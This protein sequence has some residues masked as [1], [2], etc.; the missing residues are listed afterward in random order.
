MRKKLFM[1]ILPAS[2]LLSQMQMIQAEDFAGNEDYYNNLCAQPQETSADVQTCANYKAYLVSKSDALSNEIASLNDKLSNV[3]GNMDSLLSVIS[4]IDTKLTSIETEIASSEALIAT[5]QTNITN[6]QTD[7]QEKEEDIQER[8]E[9]VKTRMQNEQVNIGINQY[10]DFIMGAE[11]LMSLI[12]IVEGLNVIT[13]YDQELIAT[14]A[15]ERE[16]LKLDKEEQIR[17]E[18]EAEDQRQMLE[19]NKQNQQVL[20]SHQETALAQYQSEEA[21]LIATKRTMEVSS[22]VLANN[23][24]H[25]NPELIQEPDPTP[26]SDGGNGDSGNSGSGIT[27]GFLWPV[28]NSY[29][30]AGTWAYPSGYT[31]LGM[32][33]AA[34]IGNYIIA[35]SDGYV[36]ATYNGCGNG[37]TSCGYVAGTGN[38]VHMLTKMNGKTYAMSFFHQNPGGPQVSAGQYVSAGQVIGIVGNSGWSEGP[39]CHVEVFD[40]GD[41]SWSE[42]TRRFQSGYYGYSGDISWGSGWSTPG[43]GNRIRPESVF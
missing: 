3:Q 17:L 21:Q 36:L 13:T 6:L 30:S 33:L 5:I 29:I 42:A 16:Q 35:P 18:Q 10:I 39:H 25:V 4:E 15:E 24:T 19:T 26:P 43:A 12:R 20:K 41:I 28:N 2:L 31:H 23:I 7:I 11:D 8:D 27:G 38:M 40:L 14:L 1:L 9:L 34:G 22:D 32:D 37:Y